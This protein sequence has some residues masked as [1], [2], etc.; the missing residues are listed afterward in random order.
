MVAAG[1]RPFTRQTSAATSIAASSAPALALA[2]QGAGSANPAS[3]SRPQPYRPAS[4]PRITPAA[5]CTASRW[6]ASGRFMLHATTSQASVAG[7]APPMT[8]EVRASHSSRPPFPNIAPTATTVITNS[9]ARR[10]T[11]TW[12]ASNTSA[13]ASRGGA[14]G[15]ARSWKVDKICESFIRQQGLTPHYW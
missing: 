11:P 3:A 14:T 8:S 10:I 13:S 12:Q 15:R 9:T 5:Y 6:R 2:S 4:A 1:V 7:K